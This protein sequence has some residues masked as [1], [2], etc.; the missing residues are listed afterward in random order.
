MAS[1]GVTAAGIA[2]TFEETRTKPDSVNG[3][4]AQGC[5]DHLVSDRLRRLANVEHGEAILIVD[6]Q[7]GRDK[8]AAHQVGYHRAECPPLGARNRAS[9]LQHVVVKV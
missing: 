3:V 5:P 2:D 7:L 4:V 8:P 1:A 9:G 6:A